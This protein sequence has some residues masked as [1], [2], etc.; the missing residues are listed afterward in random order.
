MLPVPPAAVRPMRRSVSQ[1]FAP[2]PFSQ[3]N[4][5]PSASGF[6]ATESDAVADL[7]EELGALYLELRE[8]PDDELGQ[9]PRRWKRGLE[10]L[11]VADAPA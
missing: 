10:R 8:I 11:A 6:G 3:M 4:T 2:P 7:K 5:G 1:R 9:I